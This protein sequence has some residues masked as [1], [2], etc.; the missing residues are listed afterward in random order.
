V[1]DLWSPR[2]RAGDGPRR[3]PAPD[4]WDPEA[5]FDLAAGELSRRGEAIRRADEQ[6]GALTCVG[7]A[8][9]DAVTVTLHGAQPGTRVVTAIAFASDAYRGRD[10]QELGEL[11]LAALRDAE[12]LARSRAGEITAATDWL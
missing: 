3:A 2:P 7:R 4:R 10:A 1:A 11:V 6:L 8:G 12:A 5:D 9:D